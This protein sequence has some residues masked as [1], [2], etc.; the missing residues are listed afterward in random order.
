M[1]FM[2]QH[3]VR[4]ED[5]VIA[6]MLKHEQHTEGRVY[7]RQDEAMRYRPAPVLEMKGCGIH[8]LRKEFVAL[9]CCMAIGGK[10]IMYGTLCKEFT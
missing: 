4:L 7:Y 2:L 6:H 9:L 8:G 1:L 3:V 5:Y 10:M